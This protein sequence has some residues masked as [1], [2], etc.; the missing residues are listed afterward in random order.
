MGIASVAHQTA[1]STIRAPVPQAAWLR[2][3]GGPNSNMSAARAGPSINPI[4]RAPNSTLLFPH[5]L[6][7]CP[8]IGNQVIY[9]LQTD[10]YAEQRADLLVNPVAF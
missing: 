2:P 10:M 7:P 1:I 5:S 4:L 9:G 8:E 6:K 3:S